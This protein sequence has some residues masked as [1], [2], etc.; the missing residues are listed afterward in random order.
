MAVRRGTGVRR[1]GARAARSWAGARPSPRPRRPPRRAAGPTHALP[2]A[3]SPW[4]DRTHQC[5]VCRASATTSRS[6]PC[7]CAAQVGTGEPSTGCQLPMMRMTTS[8]RSRA[9]VRRWTRIAKGRRS[10]ARSVSVRRRSADRR[11]SA[12]RRHGDGDEVQDADPRQPD[13]VRLVEQE[14]QGIGPEPGG[15]RRPRARCGPGDAPRPARAPRGASLQG[16]RP[17]TSAIA[18]PASGT[19]PLPPGSRPNSGQPAPSSAPRPAAQPAH[20]DQVTMP[21]ATGRRPFARSPVSASS[22]QPGPASLQ[23]S[24]GP[25]LATRPRPRGRRRRRARPPDRSPPGGWTRP[26]SPPTRA[27]AAT[28]MSTGSDR[29]V[30]RRAVRPGPAPRPGAPG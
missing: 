10:L 12:V 3:R 17:A 18:T 1:A 21:I 5:Q 25:G 7:R 4:G 24:A 28:R 26:G 2:P 30:D 29:A 23:T 6:R 9:I 14:Q 13:Q 15:D 27:S 8:S 19:T 20:H 22:P 16:R 11:R